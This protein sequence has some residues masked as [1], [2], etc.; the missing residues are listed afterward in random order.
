MA[1]YKSLGPDDVS[2]IPFNANK[3]FSFHSGSSS[4]P[5]V[6]T[7]TVGISFQTFEYPTS[8]LDTFS[9]GTDTNNSIKYQQLDHLFYK[10]HLRD[11]SNRFGDADYLSQKRN[12]YVKVNVISIPSNLFGNKIK[13]GT[14]NLSGSFGELIDDKKGNLIISGTNLNNFSIDEKEKIFDL[15]PLKGFK[16]YDVNYN[17]Y[18]KTTP[19][20]LNYYNKSNIYD[21]SYY[22]NIIEYKNITFSPENYNLTTT[23][24]SKINFLSSDS[25]TSSIVAPHNETY[26]FNPKEDFTI[27]FYTTPISASA[28]LLSK[29]T[30]KTLVKTPVYLKTNTTGSSQ[31]FSV[32]E[33]NQ[34]PFEIFINDT[35]NLTFRKSDGTNIPTIIAPINTGSLQHVVCMSSASVMEIWID[36]SKIS[37]TTDTT[38]NQTENQ[39]NLYIG[40]KGEISNYY[41]GSLSNIK[42]FNSS[43]TTNQIKNLSSSLDGNPYIGNIFY[44]N[45]IATITHPKYQDTIAKPNNTELELSFKNI[46]PIYENEYQCTVQADEYNF[47]HNI[48]T[49]KIKSD[50]KPDLANFTTGSQFKPY[51]TTIG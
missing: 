16:Q 34:Y 24:G 28:Y 40:S 6:E 49:R 21:D 41:T 2:R 43:K 25:I 30:T 38:T 42:I 19:N 26:N 37:S 47:T 23:T 20:L 7:N 29:S 35:Q 3:Q 45:G 44:S 12:L 8:T 48:S 50:Q 14:F 22:S 36:G 27:S 46:H 5:L 33:K 39:A 10:N 9:N 11:I 13:P 31:P 17:L 4:S 32:R 1:I 15:N 18:G 51:V